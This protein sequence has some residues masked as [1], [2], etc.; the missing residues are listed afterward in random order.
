MGRDGIACALVLIVGVLGA[1][2]QQG[3]FAQ[4]N[5]AGEQCIA[6]VKSLPIRAPHLPGAIR[7]HVPTH[8]FVTLV[9]PLSSTDTLTIYELGNWARYWAKAEKDRAPDELTDPDSRLL[10]T[11]RGDPVFRY[12]LKDLR[13]PKGDTDDWGV[14]AEVMDAA[15]LCSGD[16]DITYLVLQS[17]NQGGLFVA[18]QKVAEGYKLISISDAAQ[19]RLVLSANSPHAIEVWD[20][21]EIGA[22]TACFKPFIVK[23]LEFNGTDYRLVSEHKTRKWYRGFQD[24]PLVVRR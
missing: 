17:G 6:S 18:L 19:G 10:I 21:D 8:A 4:R 7:A 20:A 23:T 15:H 5:A 9:L 3:E 24:Q 14:S 2:G 11:R 16:L 22:C 1:L 12:A 13:M